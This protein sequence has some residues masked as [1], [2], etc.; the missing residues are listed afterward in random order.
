MLVGRRMIFELKFRFE[1]IKYVFLIEE[2]G[3]KWV[4]TNKIR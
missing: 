3:D 2:N 1:N 4:E